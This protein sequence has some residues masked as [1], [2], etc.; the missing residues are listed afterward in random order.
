MSRFFP[1][2]AHPHVDLLSYMKHK[3]Y[4]KKKKNMLLFSQTLIKQT[5]TRFVSM[6]YTH[7]CNV[8][9]VNFELNHLEPLYDAR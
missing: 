6:V 3:S 5:I 4:L 7:I 9:L 2:F 1:A 8:Q